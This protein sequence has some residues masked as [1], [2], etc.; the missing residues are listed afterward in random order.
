MMHQ[1]KYGSGTVVGKVRTHN[2]DCFR[3][4]PDMGFWLVAD[5]MGG[6][7][8]GEVASVLAADLV[9]EGVRDGEPLVEPI[10]RAHHAILEAT[11]DGR[12]PVGM[13]T[14]VVALKLVGYKYKIAWVGDCRAYLWDGISLKQL[15]RDHSYVQYLVD[16][17]I[18]PPE[19]IDSHAHQNFIMQA[20]GATELEDVD[21]GYIDDT[22]YRGEQILLCSDGLNK[23][24]DDD[25]IAAILRLD[26]NEQEKVDIL[27]SQS[28]EHGGEDNITVSLISADEDAP[29]R[30]WK[31]KFHSKILSVISAIRDYIYN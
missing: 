2:E 20:L 4:E 10:A 13:G 21:V 30:D 22:L 25:G 28:V 3:S 12:G 7:L 5:G 26:L 14:T 17:G 18:I 8:G 31:V 19:E 27:L 29:V 11:A 9:V 16:E 23:E 6:H 1:F 24:I 15:T